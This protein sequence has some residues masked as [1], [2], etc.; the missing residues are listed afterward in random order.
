MEA[1]C[2]WCL[3]KLVESIQDHYT[4][5]QPGV[6]R[7]VFLMQVLV[8]KMCETWKVWVFGQ[9]DISKDSSSQGGMMPLAPDHNLPYL[10]CVKP[11]ECGCLDSQT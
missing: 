7:T 2:Y 6:Q 10:K 3:C 4:Y 1:D 8:C 9:P 5:A 11:G